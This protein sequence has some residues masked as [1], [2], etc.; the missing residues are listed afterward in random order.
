MLTEHGDPI[1]DRWTRDS[2][3]TPWMA[4]PA[5]SEPPDSAASDMVAVALAVAVLLVIFFL[6]SWLPA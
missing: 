3:R 6:A 1:H 4:H 5:G 2:E